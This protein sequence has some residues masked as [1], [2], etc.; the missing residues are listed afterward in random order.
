M[1]DGKT[2][3]NAPKYYQNRELSWLDFNKRVILEALDDTNPLLE[4][5]GFIAIGSSNLDEFI[6]VRVA[7]LQDQH[8]LG[9]TETDSK[10]DRTP[11]KQIQEISIKNRDI[12]KQQYDIYHQKMVE[13]ESIGYE[14][15][16]IASL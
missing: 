15:A 5:L 13:L 7:G 9:V 3:L 8:K 11:K 6:Q 1:E 16:S 14:V 2:N 10:K 12:V 4:Q